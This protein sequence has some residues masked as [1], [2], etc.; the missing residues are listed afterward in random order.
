[1]ARLTAGKAS[2]S[3]GKN[4][5][6][7]ARV[8]STD[9]PASGTLS[10]HAIPRAI[11][12]S[13]LGGETCAI[14][15]PS[16]NSTMEWTKDWG[17]TTTS[18]RSKGMSNSRWASMT[19]SPL[20]TSVAELVV[21]TGPIAQDGWAR[22]C[23]GVTVSSAARLQ[24]RKGPPLAVIMSL[25]TSAPVPPRRHWAMALCSLSTGTIWPG[26]AAAL[27]SEPPTIRDSLLAR[28]RVLPAFSAARGQ[29]GARL[30]PHEDVRH[31]PLSPSLI[32]YLVNG[33]C[34][35]VALPAG[36]ADCLYPERNRL[37]RQQ[38]QVPATS[39][40]RAHPEP[41]GVG[42]YDLDGLGAD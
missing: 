24:P 6:V 39:A 32:R 31:E 30:L 10:G 2:S 33:G 42:R 16:M 8:Q 14:V 18:M 41:P 12:I 40:D 37:A 4:S 22:A 28:A 17:W 21:M 19:S 25:R 11:G 1:M 26:L 13:M 20:L 27:T 5:Q 36:D 7:A 15:D 38:V 35:D 23:S 29:I 9:G 3:S 34:H